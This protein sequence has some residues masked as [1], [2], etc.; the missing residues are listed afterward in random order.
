MRTAV[1][2]MDESILT[3]DA[4]SALLRFVP[5]K[6]EIAAAA[7]YEGKMNAIDSVLFYD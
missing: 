6:N 1:D 7:S 4:C 2:T 5:E 3:P